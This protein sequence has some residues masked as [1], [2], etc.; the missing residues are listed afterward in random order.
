VLAE[1]VRG[2]LF[3]V[4]QSQRDAWLAQLPLLREVAGHTGMMY[5]EYAIPRMGHRIDSV[6][7]VNGIILT[8]EFKIDAK[9]YLRGDIDQAYDYAIDLKYFHEAS[10][11]LPVVPILVASRAHARPFSLAPHPRVSG[12]YQTICTNAED[13]ASTWLLGSILGKLFQEPAKDLIHVL[14]RTD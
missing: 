7:L 2:S 13:L 12:L 10:H 14:P 3:P 1:L 8:I 9:E 6:V 11:D 5:L 4:L